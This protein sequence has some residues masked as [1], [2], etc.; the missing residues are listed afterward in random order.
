V[1]QISL[2][3]AANRAVTV[4]EIAAEVGPRLARALL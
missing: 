2:A 1:P 4:E 3:R